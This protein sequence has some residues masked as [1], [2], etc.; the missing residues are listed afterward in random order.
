MYFNWWQHVGMRLTSPIAYPR[1]HKDELQ[2]ITSLNNS[3][4]ILI[5]LSNTLYLALAHVV[6]EVAPITSP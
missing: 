4:P 5:P 3:T 2:P 6:H 1:I